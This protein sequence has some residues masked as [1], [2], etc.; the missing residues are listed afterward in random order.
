MYGYPFVSAVVG[1]V[2]VTECGAIV[3]A[4]FGSFIRS[5]AGAVGVSECVAVKSAVGVT[6]A[7]TDLISCVGSI[8]GTV[9]GAFV[10]PQCGSYE[11]TF[12]GTYPGVV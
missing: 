1:S 9:F 11:S 7:C 10:H 8:V 5:H 12:R 6:V 2:R 3:A 4:F